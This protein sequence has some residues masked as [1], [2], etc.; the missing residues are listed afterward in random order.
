[1]HSM[2]GTDK[3]LFQT[4]ALR[5]GVNFSQAGVVD[6]SILCVSCEHSLKDCD[7]YAIRWVRSFPKHAVPVA[8]GRCFEMQNTKPRLLLKFVCSVIWRHAVSIHN[9]DYDMDLGPWEVRL[10]EFIFHG[11]AF[12]PLFFVARHQ[13][14]LRSLRLEPICIAPYRNPS[15]GRRGWLFEVGGFLWGL[16][17]DQRNGGGRV[18]EPPFRAN[19]A[20]PVLVLNL[21]SKDV[22]SNEGMMRL[23][24]NM[25]LS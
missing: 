8:D 17:L 5:R 11:G 21:P 3:H 10:R 9:Q 1:M 19:D 24:G 25:D 16:K 2:R 15:W 20:N 22:L 13:W 4:E 14:S 6:K 23:I 12:N 7:D 18:F